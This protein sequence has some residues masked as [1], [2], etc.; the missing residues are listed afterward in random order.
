MFWLPAPSASHP[1]KLK[2]SRS[3]SLSRGHGRLDITFK[4]WTGDFDQMLKRRMIRALVPYSRSL[5]F[6][7]K[8]RERGITAD[9]VRDFE[10][11]L[12]KKYAKKLRKRPL[13]VYLI[14]TTRDKLLPEVAKGI[15]RHRH[16]TT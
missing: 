8:G 6:N 16:W 5:Y 7:D 11:W 9:N 2:P 15:G 4:P 3:P 1:D 13:T 12:N 10:R 14:P